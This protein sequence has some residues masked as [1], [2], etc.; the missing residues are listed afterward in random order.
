MC[1][2]S[3]W[4]SRRERRRDDV[5]NLINQLTLAGQIHGGVVQGH[6]PGGRRGRN[7]RALAAIMN[8]VVDALS[9]LGIARID[10]PATPEKVWRAIRAAPRC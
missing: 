7:V 4:T 2:R 10:M 1:S 9:P 5:G 8:A 3:R 6:Q